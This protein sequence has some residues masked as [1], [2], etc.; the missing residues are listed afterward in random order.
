MN[1]WR[2][3]GAVIFLVGVM[4]LVLAPGTGVRAQ[5]KK[6]QKEAKQDKKDDEKKQET[7][8]EVKA[9][10]A[11]A[12]EAKGGGALKFTA[13]DPDGKPFY[14]ELKTETIQ[15]MK[16]MGQEIDQKQDQTFVIEWTPRKKDSEGNYVVA[17]KIVGI[18]MNIDI[19]GNKIAYDST[20]K[21]PKNP[22]T[23][24]FDQLLKQELEFH[25]TPDLK[26]K[27]VKGRDEFVK[28]LG[29]TNPQMQGLLKQILSKEALEKMAEPTWWALPPGG[30]ATKGKGWEK[31]STLDLGPIGKYDTTYNFTYDSKD[32]KNLDKILIKADL[33]YT[34]P[35]A[36]AAGGLPFTI[37]DAKLAG[38]TAT[39]EA[40]FDSA[41]GRFDASKMDMKL[42]GTLS[43]VV[44]NMTTDITLDQ[45][46]KSSSKTHDANPWQGAG[47]SEKTEKK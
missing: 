30:E 34:A 37:K 46:Q 3:F 11:K 12:T 26:V 38:K 31:K 40:Y 7:K 4:G 28:S 8:Q 35:G 25:I 19:G 41:K 47:A 43:I 10:E 17:Q 32:S 9:P 36:N 5:D 14:Q 13:F 22:M 27:D 6:D 45:D 29:E 20:A 18:K 1:L 16:V 39:G 33:T 21:N 2:W 15:K 24:F 42:N 44:G 23:D